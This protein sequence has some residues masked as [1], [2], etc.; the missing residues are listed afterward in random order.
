VRIGGPRGG[1]PLRKPEGEEQ[2][3]RVCVA[4]QRQHVPLRC[5]AVRTLGVALQQLHVV[6]DSH[7]LATLVAFTGGGTLR[8][9]TLAQHCVLPGDVVIE[10]GD[11]LLPLASQQLR[12]V[13]QRPESGHSTSLAFHRGK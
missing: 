5:A 11:L 7:L 4:G 8:L 10:E 12:V 6:G 13:A 2:L 9:N 3:G 1:A